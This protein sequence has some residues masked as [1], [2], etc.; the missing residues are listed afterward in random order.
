MQDIQAPLT[1]SGA[2]EVA[3]PRPK[4]AGFSLSLAQQP[5]VHLDEGEIPA[6]AATSFSLLTRNLDAHPT[7]SLDLRQ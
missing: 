7:L 4:I 2:L 5:D 6:G 1:F 3:G